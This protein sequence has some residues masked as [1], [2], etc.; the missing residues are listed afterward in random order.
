MSGL[1]TNHVSRGK[2]GTH[3]GAPRSTGDPKATAVGEPLAM[4]AGGE[5]A[6]RPEVEEVVEEDAG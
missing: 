5:P 3:A 4:S 2:C 6:G 1:R